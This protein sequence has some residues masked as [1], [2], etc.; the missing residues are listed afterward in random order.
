VDLDSPEGKTALAK[1]TKGAPEGS[2]RATPLG[3]FVDYVKD[4]ASTADL[5]ARCARI[6][7]LSA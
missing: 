7:N 5:K 1:L 3:A 2:A 6:P 4:C